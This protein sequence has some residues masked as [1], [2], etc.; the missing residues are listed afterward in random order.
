M[1]SFGEIAD[2]MELSRNAGKTDDMLARED[3]CSCAKPHG[4]YGRGPWHLRR[5]PDHPHSPASDLAVERCPEYARVL[6]DLRDWRKSAKAIELELAAAESDE[7]PGSIRDR[8]A[9][10]QGLLVQQRDAQDRIAEL[11]RK[12]A[13]MKGTSR[14]EDSR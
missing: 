6:S 4:V 8:R 12:I 10:E 5:S 13:A 3:R 9:R 14:Q 11:E 7:D 1:K 2:G